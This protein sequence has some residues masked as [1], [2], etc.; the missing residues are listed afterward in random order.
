MSSHT[1][2][3]WIEWDEN[4]LTIAFDK[5]VPVWGVR[6]CA[7]SVK[8]PAPATP[9]DGSVTGSAFGRTVIFERIDR[10]KSNNLK[11]FADL[12]ATQ[13]KMTATFGFLTVNNDLTARAYANKFL[14]TSLCKK[15]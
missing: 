4:W 9:I 3:D 6:S 12:G 1:W 7:T 13:L 5:I 10:S 14:E 2:L 8:F 11:Q 15:V